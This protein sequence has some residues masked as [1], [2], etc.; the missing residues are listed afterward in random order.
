MSFA[1]DFHVHSWFSYDALLAPAEAFKAAR[2]LGVS[3]IAITDHYNMDGFGAFRAASAAS[4][5][6]TWVPG[7]ELSVATSFRDR[8]VVALGVP[9]NAPELLEDVVMC[10]RAWMR[11]YNRALLA[12]FEALGIPFGEEEKHYLLD[13]SRPGEASSIQG[14]VRLPI[15]PLEAWLVNAGVISDRME[16]S[17]LVERAMKAV[18]G[19]PPLP[20]ADNV[21]PRFRKLGALLI[22]AHPQRFLEEYGEK[23]LDALVEETG[24][25]GIEAGHLAHS[26]AQAGR[27]VEYAERRGMLVSGGTD[28]HLPGEAQFIGQWM[29]KC[30]QVDKNGHFT[31]DIQVTGRRAFEKKQVLPLLERLSIPVRA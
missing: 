18:G 12:G 9:R 21:L 23:C 2:R 8:D 24:V 13:T 14:E 11:N 28:T 16:F 31:R 7:M 10:Y 15:L 22:L 27:Y 5:G 25:E 6:V 1:F 30:R 17:G 3:A 4:P 26:E 19:M 29:S 20:D